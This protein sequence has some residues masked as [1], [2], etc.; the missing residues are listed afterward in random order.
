MLKRTMYNHKLLALFFVY[1]L[2]SVGNLVQAKDNAI[3]IEADKV[4]LDEKSGISYYIGN[5]KL[6]QANLSITADKLTVFTEN[7]ELSRIVASGNPAHF[8]RTPDD[9]T[10]NTVTA[11]AMTIEFNAKQQTLKLS[12]DVRLTHGDN[13]FSGENVS[14]DILNNIMKATGSETK[15]RVQ[16]VIQMDTLKQK[17]K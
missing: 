9:R 6:S 4:E 15:K 2:L 7:E 8:L 13:H 12:G 14:Y 1:I 3:H 5:V 17:A 16:A 10:P 11:Q